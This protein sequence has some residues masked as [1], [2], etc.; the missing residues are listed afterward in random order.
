MPAKRSI[1]CKMLEGGTRPFV[2]V[3]GPRPTPVPDTVH[4]VATPHGPA[5]LFMYDN[6]QGARLVMLVP[7]METEK[8]GPMTEHTDGSVAGF[9]WAQNGLGYSLVGVASPSVLHPL[10]NEARR[11]IQSVT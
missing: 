9:A 7:P 1:P 10:A 3:M 5:G 11:Q 8:D 2:T 6:S 4:P